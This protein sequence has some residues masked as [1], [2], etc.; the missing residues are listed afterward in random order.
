MTITATVEQDV[1]QGGGVRRITVRFDDSIDGSESRN[2]YR[3][4]IGV[5]A[6]VFADGRALDLE[7]S[8]AQQ[9]LET[10]FELVRGGQN[11]TTLIWLRNTEATGEEWICKGA[12]NQTDAQQIANFAHIHREYGSQTI[13]AATGLSNP[14]RQAWSGDAQALETSLNQY[15]AD[16]TNNPIYR[17]DGFPDV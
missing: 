6:Q 15:I 5:D 3:I 17:F 12:S 2:T 10:N 13:N 1:D 11:A 4:A 14:E 9:E 8:R 7:M 16:H